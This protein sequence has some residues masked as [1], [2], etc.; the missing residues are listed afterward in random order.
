M[1]QND[2]QETIDFLKTLPETVSLEEI[3]YHLIVRREIF[4][5]LKDIKENKTIPHEQVVKEMETYME[6]L[7]ERQ[8]SWKDWLDINPEICFNKIRIK[9]TRIYISLIFDF[10]T[11]GESEGAILEEYPS[12]TKEDIRA[13]MSYAAFVLYHRRILS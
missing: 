2:K 9:G 5:G 6:D 3:I 11:V 13:A 8:Y 7:K 12:L 10:F 1:V 4:L